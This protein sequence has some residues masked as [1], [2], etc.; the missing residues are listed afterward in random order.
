MG[1]HKWKLLGLLAL[2]AV[3]AA[4][5]VAL[6]PQPDRITFENCDRITEGM[7]RAEVYAILGSPGDY[8]TGPV[9]YVGEGGKPRVMDQF[10]MP[11]EAADYAAWLSDE[12]YVVVHLGDGGRVKQERFLARE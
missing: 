2:L 10:G 7:S 6:W 5:A 12:A 1:K 4:T 3:I 9:V 8:R 11:F